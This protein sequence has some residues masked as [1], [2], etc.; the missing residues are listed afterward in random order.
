M[1]VPRAIRH[2]TSSHFPPLDQLDGPGASRTCRGTVC[3]RVP[4]FPQLVQAC[5]PSRLGQPCITAANGRK[6][7]SARTTGAVRRMII[8]P[9]LCRHNGAFTK[10]QQVRT[11]KW[12]A[13]RLNQ[14]RK[15]GLR[16]AWLGLSRVVGRWCRLSRPLPYYASRMSALS[17]SLRNRRRICVLRSLR[18]RKGVTNLPLIQMRC[19]STETNT[20]G[21]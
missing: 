13:R 3:P 2:L 19:G 20:R 18:R 7:P 5:R 9:G 12:A 14:T 4:G 6:L 8:G 10:F 16:T 21:P 15:A 17:A 11:P 1:G